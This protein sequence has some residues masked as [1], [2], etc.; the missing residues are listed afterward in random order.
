MD[1]RWCRRLAATPYSF[2]ESGVNAM[3]GA[4]GSKPLP[5]IASGMPGWMGDAAVV[6]GH[7]SSL[8]LSQADLR[9]ADLSEANLDDADLRNVR[10]N[11]ADMSNGL[12]RGAN[13]MFTWGWTDAQLSAARSL[14]EATMLNGQ[15]YEDWL[16]SKGSGEND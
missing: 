16:K 11:G 8:S 7:L 1:A 2:L 3:E 12:L 5:S 15:K 10:L 14:E 9:K 6:W 4:V 13:L